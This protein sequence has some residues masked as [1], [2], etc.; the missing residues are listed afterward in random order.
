MIGVYVDLVDGILF[1]SKNGDIFTKNAFQG[2]A[3]LSNKFYPAAA[4]LSRNEMFELIE[5]QA[6]DWDIW[7]QVN[8]A[9]R[10]DLHIYKW[11]FKE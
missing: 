4:C 11:N 3:L 2:S 1:F 8:W 7:R 9:N 6:E 5:P 10:K